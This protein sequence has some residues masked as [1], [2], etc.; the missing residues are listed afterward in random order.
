MPKNISLFFLGLSGLL[1]G[2]GLYTFIYAKGFS[3]FSNDP[4]ACMNC[5]IMREHYDS[6]NKSSHRGITTCNSCH[7]PQEFYLKYFYKAEN[8]FMHALKFTTGD[9]KE[10]L[11]IRPHNFKM[12]MKACL[13]CHGHLF[14]DPVHQENLKEARSC[15]HCH[16]DIGH[17]H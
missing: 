1:I 15:V 13:N 2:F 16:R 5:H 8:G 10:P 11:K 6:W 9:F 14:H 12:S 4:K 7:E 17:I 3:Y